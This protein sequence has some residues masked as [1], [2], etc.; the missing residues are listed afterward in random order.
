[1]LGLQV[2]GIDLAYGVL[3]LKPN[4]LF[5]L[6][7]CSMNCPHNLLEISQLWGGH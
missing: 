6:D 2:C 4:A 7:K 5:V 3:G 1:M